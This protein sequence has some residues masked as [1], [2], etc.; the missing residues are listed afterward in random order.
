MSAADVEVVRTLVPDPSID[1]AQ[2]V[3]TEELAQ[4]LE[5]AVRHFFQPEFA[6]SLVSVIEMKHSGFEGL[7]AIWKEWLE[8]W[9]TYRVQEEE[10]IDLND[11]RVVWLGQDVAGTKH[12]GNEVVLNSSAIWRIQSGRVAA[13]SFFAERERCLE[14]AGLRGAG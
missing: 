13:V 1:W 3:R 5:D 7:L 11:G 6:C 9:S 10:I 4:P 12:G 8:P 14:E 2:I